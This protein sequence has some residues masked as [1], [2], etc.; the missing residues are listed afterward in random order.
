MSKICCSTKRQVRFRILQAKIV[1]KYIVLEYMLPH[2]TLWCTIVRG[3]LKPKH[4]G[5]YPCIISLLIRNDIC[6]YLRPGLCV[7]RCADTINHL[8]T[9]DIFIL[10]YE[11][12]GMHYEEYDIAFLFATG[13]AWR[14]LGE[15]HCLCIQSTLTT[16]QYTQYKN[17]LSRYGKTYFKHPAE[18]CGVLLKASSRL[19]GFRL[20][21]G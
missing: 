8:Y 17:G 4:N 18:C 20:G 21:L 10:D 6:R 9:G 12:F 5:D 13:P 15:Q 16:Y 7:E 3:H 1:L 11:M 14:L 19:Y 2:D